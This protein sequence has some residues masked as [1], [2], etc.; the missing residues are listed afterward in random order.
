MHSPLPIPSPASPF[1]PGIIP[2]KP[3]KW[4]Y[5]N[6]Q[7][8]PSPSRCIIQ[9]LAGGFGCSTMAGIETPNDA[10][11]EHHHYHRHGI[12]L[13]RQVYRRHRVSSSSS[14]GVRRLF[15]WSPPK[16]HFET[17]NFSIKVKA[18]SMHSPGRPS[19]PICLCTLMFSGKLSLGDIQLGFTDY[20]IT[21]TESLTSL[22]RSSS[23]S[24]ILPED[25]LYLCTFSKHLQS[26][27][28]ISL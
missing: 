14:S 21:G 3:Q 13:M 2:K 11:E 28:K 6:S 5:F 23:S 9:S 16:S 4:L 17:L 10:A 1:R 24:S 25:T 18:P 19:K 8:T 15:C 22:L 20:L 12:A 7:H 27:T 26:I